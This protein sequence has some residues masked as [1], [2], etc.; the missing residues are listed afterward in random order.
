MRWIRT[1][2]GDKMHVVLNNQT[3]T[4]CGISI[5]KAAAIGPPGMHDRCEACDHKWR[6]SVSRGKR[7][8]NATKRA[9]KETYEPR[10]TLKDWE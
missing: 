2:N 8:A 4:I 3:H 5:T 6:R 10:F 7:T 1:T 9:G